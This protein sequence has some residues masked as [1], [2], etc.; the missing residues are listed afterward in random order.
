LAKTTRAFSLEKIYEVL[1]SI[2]NN[3]RTAS[4]F[5]PEHEA[6]ADMLGRKKGQEF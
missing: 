1:V 4:F 5:S 6:Q 2:P 3:Q